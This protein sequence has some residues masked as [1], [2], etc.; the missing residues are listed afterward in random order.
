MIRKAVFLVLALLLPAGLLAQRYCCIADLET[1]VP[2]RDVII[3][4]N[5]N[6]WART[7]YRGYWNMPYAFDSITVTKSG[8]VPRTVR[9]A[10]LPDTLF[11]LPEAHQL[12]T[13]EV[14]GK[15]QAS[16]R[17]MEE[18]IQDAVDQEPRQKPLLSFDLGSMLDKRA[19]RDR[20]HRR[21]A[22]EIFDEM[23]K[24]D[25]PVTDAY[26]EATGKDAK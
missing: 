9:N 8:Y 16:I 4:T 25:D 1:H 2:L 26:E 17:A 22:H 24:A 23:D 12:G 7:D 14:W 15:N 20:K 5:T 6:H 10:E 19:R 13:V 11:L 18:R 3:R 21:K